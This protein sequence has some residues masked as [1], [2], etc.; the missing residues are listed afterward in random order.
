VQVVFT[1]AP[2]LR[3]RPRGMVRRSL[4]G[5]GRVPAAAFSPWSQP[6]LDQQQT[7]AISVLAQ[8][9]PGSAR[10]E[11]SHSTQ[12]GPASGAT[13]MPGPGG[14]PRTPSASLDEQSKVMVVGVHV[15]GHPLCLRPHGWPP[16]ASMCHRGP[17]RAGPPPPAR[18]SRASQRPH[19]EPPARG[20]ASH[21]RCAGFRRL[22]RAARGPCRGAGCSPAGA[23]AGPCAS[24]VPR[25]RPAAP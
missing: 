13:P 25:C 2:V 4:T 15:V 23:L 20:A 16:A 18:P 22:V 5:T 17:H 21:G 19:E 1:E 24:W 3:R 14:H 12:M 9:A 10:L 11:R 8:R 7:P 6:D